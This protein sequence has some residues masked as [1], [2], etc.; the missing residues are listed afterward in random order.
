MSLQELSN[1]TFQSRYSQYNYD[2]GRK[3]V[4]DEAVKRIFDTH[5]EKYKDI[6]FIDTVNHLINEAEKVQKQKRILS[7]QRML[8]TGGNLVLKRNERQYNCCGIAI[9]KPKAFQDIMW[10]L[11]AGCGVGFSVQ[12]FDIEKLPKIQDLTH[13]KAKY[14]HTIEDS[15]EGWAD[16]VGVLL[17]SYFDSNQFFDGY[18]DSSI[19]F[20]YS[21]IRPKGSLIA[22]QFKAPGPEPLK[23]GLEKIRKI[24]NNASNRQLKSLEV[25]DICMHIAD[26]V[27]SSGLRR[28]ATICLFSKD[29]EEMSAAKTGN[30]F[31]ENPQR[32]RSN[33][34][35][36][37]N[38]KTTSKEEFSK[39]FK[40]TK[41][42]GEP[43]WVF[44]NSDTELCN[45]CAEIKWDVPRIEGKN[46]IVSFC[47]L[48]EINGKYCSTK[49]EFFE[50]CRIGA[51]IGTLQ[52]GY[53]DFPYL[54]KETEEFVKK[55][56]LLGVSITGWMENP[57]ILLDKDILLEGSN[58]VKETN[59]NVAKILGINAAARLCTVKPAGHTSCIL[60]TSSGIHPH[61]AKRYIRRV[62]SNKLEG[63]A[64]Y[65]ESVNPSAVEESVWSANNT[66]VVMSFLCEVPKG[67]ITKNQVSA[68]D[69]LDKVKTAQ[70]YWV[71]NGVNDDLNITKGLTHSV[72]NTITVLPEEWD[73]VEDYIYNNRDNFSGIS[74]LPASGD[75]DYPQAPFSTVLTPTELVKEYGDASVFASGLVVDGL[76]AFNN[77][78]WAACD[79][80]LGNG[81][82]LQSYFVE[83]EYPKTRNY[84]DLANYFADKESYESWFKKRDWVRRLNKFADKYFEGSLKRATY[85]C[86]HVSLWKTWVDLKREYKEVDWTK[87]ESDPEYLD[88]DTLAA[89]ACSGGSCELK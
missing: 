3:E 4:W 29:D 37:I 12:K 67:S 62:Q 25:Y 89:Q 40:N 36:I 41:E 31:V 73:Q 9:D 43:G 72:S 18:K 1:Y 50:L 47:N 5:R 19:E 59:K 76:T 48:C 8:Q 75:L 52:A 85:C 32:G 6:E 83:P 65:F 24:L 45:P 87:M 14:I 17:S 54:G 60:S 23:N 74:L 28:S 46:C 34:S 80:A 39:L 49:E 26:S 13:T 77:N 38:R 44:V 56:A 33:N 21:E 30:W 55:E 22:G 27:V 11:L 53:T 20:D 71:N 16:A 10:L 86:K 61:H 66:D 2:K 64:K 78:L 15:C 69:L 88:A 68:L 81:E 7:S 82:K 70:E 58:I 63:A 57:E 79:C 42:Y 35:A 84:K 51:I